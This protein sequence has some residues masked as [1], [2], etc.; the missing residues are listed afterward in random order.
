MS[1]RAEG[2]PDRLTAVLSA[3]LARLSP[4]PRTWWVAYSGGLDSTV[5]LHAMAALRARTGCVL[6]A[7]HIDH[8]LQS[9]S[10]RWTRTCAAVCERLGIPLE[11]RSLD[12]RPARGE[13]PEAAARNARYRALAGLLGDGDCLLTAHHRD[14]QAETLLLQLLRGAGPHGL[15]AMPALESFARGFHA[16]PFLGLDRGDLEAWAR[17]AGLEWIED[18]SNFDVGF[19]R[20]YLR[21]EILPRLRVHWPAL[22]RTLARS[23]AHCAAAAAVIDERAE[24][25]LAWAAGPEP[26]TLAADVVRSLPRPRADQLLRRWLTGL[27][28][29][30]PAAAVLE[31]LHGDV[32]GAR[33]DAVPLLAWPGA[34][35]RRYRNRLYAAAPLAAHDSTATLPWEALDASTLLLPDGSRLI[36]RRAVG[37]GL[38]ADS[39]AAGLSVRY[40]RGGESCRPVTGNH[41]RSLAR[42]FQERA[43]PPWLRDRIPLVYVG[44]SLALVPGVCIDRRFCASPHEDAL[45]IEWLHGYAG[46]RN[47][48]HALA[49]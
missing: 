21:H 12:A 14:D 5:L 32:I 36:A 4:G 16:R 30:V 6:R 49:R 7:A 27:G 24:D 40:R 38:S 47:V 10:A 2:A 43:I 13:S 41:E 9:A 45:E 11:V 15:A 28:L 17:E 3:A 46:L 44:D 29:P 1:T 37:R 25:D 35:V 8:G 26:G 34:E 22:G 31:R 33:A 23:A 19:R 48:R 20:N 42:L 18:P 39:T